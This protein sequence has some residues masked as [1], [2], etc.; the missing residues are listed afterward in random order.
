LAVQWEDAMAAET[1]ASLVVFD[2]LEG[3]RQA[4]RDTYF[5]LDFRLLDNQEGPF[6]SSFEMSRFGPLEVTKALVKARSSG[7]R[8]RDLMNDR[9]PDHFVLNIVRSGLVRQ[10]QFG[11]GAETPSGFMSLFDS[12]HPL[13]TQQLTTTSAVYIRIPGAQLR[14]AIGAPEE[15]CAAPMDVR[16]GVGLV[17]YRHLQSIWRE[18]ANLPDGERVALSETLLDLFATLCRGSAGS[19][20]PSMKP[21]GAQILERAVRYIEAHLGDPALS[22]ERLAGALRISTSHLHSIAR[23][24]GPTIGRLILIKRLER[25]RSL[26][27]D[28]RQAGRRI[29]DIAFDCGFNDAA[30]FSRTFKAEF[31]L[32]PRSFRKQS[33][34]HHVTERS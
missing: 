8:G 13:E 28:G 6:F 19:P 7:R 10:R 22:P 27:A 34:G 25:C 14:A 18:R 11:R 3:Y 1:D 32:S 21:A 16:S 30:H 31:G 33:L 2:T 29:I 20:P 4:V 24:R 9:E 17:F 5:S 23:G 26:L 12:R 15:F